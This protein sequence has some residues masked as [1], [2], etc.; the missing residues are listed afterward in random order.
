MAKV[1]LELTDEHLK[2]ISCLN[3]QRL[4]DDK[5]GMDLN[6]LYGGNFVLEDVALCLGYMD[7]MIPNTN[8]D[9]D[10][11]KFP[12]ELTNK[13]MD[14]HEYIW[15]NIDWIESLVHQFVVEGGL[16]PGKYQCT[17][18]QKVWTKIE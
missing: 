5:V 15:D 16:T 9:W 10:G 14:L 1:T 11:P 6:S 3:Y 8:E 13:M 4:G 7:Q 18:Y 17:D 2:L 12:K